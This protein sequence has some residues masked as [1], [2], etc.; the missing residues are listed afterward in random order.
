MV[1]ALDEPVS[2]EQIA[3]V[4]EIDGIVGVRLARL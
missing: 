4:R 2:E 3:R 1:L